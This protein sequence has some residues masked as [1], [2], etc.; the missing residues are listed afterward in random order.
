MAS[1]S[2]LRFVD[3]QE[4]RIVANRTQLSRLIANS[5]FPRGFLLSANTRCWDEDEI[6]DWLETRRKASAQP[7]L[8]VA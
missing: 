3:L 5:G 1:H 8:A 4:R 2:L 7:Q 6:L